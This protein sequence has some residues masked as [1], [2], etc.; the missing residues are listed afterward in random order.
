[1]DC[2]NQSRLDK[3]KKIVKNSKNILESNSIAIRQSQTDNWETRKNFSV[4]SKYNSEQREQVRLVKCT[5]CNRKVAGKV[6]YWPGYPDEHMPIWT[7]SCENCEKW[8]SH[9]EEDN[10]EMF[11]GMCIDCYKDMGDVQK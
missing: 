7:S 11:L 3:S 5:C 4:L 2:M 8:L 1:M 9:Y 6:V 10:S